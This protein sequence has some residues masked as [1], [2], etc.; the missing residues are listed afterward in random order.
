MALEELLLPGETV[1]YRSPRKVS[2]GSE[3]YE[4]ITTGKRL[5]LYRKKG[6]LLKNEE[7]KARGIP[8]IQSISYKEEGVLPK[9]GIVQANMGGRTLTYSGPAATM[10]SVY[11]ELQRYTVHA[12]D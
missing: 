9:R 8:E 7:F 1:R 3:R 11:G 12:K 10:K 2:L 4:L 5:I 6:I